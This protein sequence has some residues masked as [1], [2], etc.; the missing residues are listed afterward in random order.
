MVFIL[1]Q[2]WRP[3]HNWLDPRKLVRVHWQYL[4]RPEEYVP[5]AYKIDVGW[6]RDL[7][8]GWCWIES[9]RVDGK[10]FITNHSQISPRW[11]DR[12]SIDWI[13]LQES[14]QNNQAQSRSFQGFKFMI[15]GQ[16]KWF[17]D[18]SSRRSKWSIWF[19][20]KVL[21]SKSIESLVRLELEIMPIGIQDSDPE[22]LGWMWVEIQE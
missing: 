14:N 7:D 12:E 10:T 21:R 20:F 5:S 19:K 11:V 1:N 15:Q 18:R 8:D 13:R 17:K 4:I 22:R 9:S 6:T 3:L 2:V 16:V